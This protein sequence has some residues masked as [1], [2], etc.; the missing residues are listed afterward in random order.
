MVFAFKVISLCYSVKKLINIFVILLLHLPVRMHMQLLIFY[1]ELE[2]CR[3]T[4]R[5]E[6][7]EALIIDE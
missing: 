7:Q 3:G 2:A 5:L 6:I 1:Y 4:Y